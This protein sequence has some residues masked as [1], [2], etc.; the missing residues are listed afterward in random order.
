MSKG[1]GFWKKL[2]AVLA[3]LS[4]VTFIFK[5]KLIK[6]LPDMSNGIEGVGDSIYTFLRNTITG[7]VLYSQKLIGGTMSS[8]I[9]YICKEILP[10]TIGTFFND[11]L[12]TALVVA[13]LSVMSMLSDSAGKQLEDYLGTQSDARG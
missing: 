13:T 4:M 8:V 2:L 9:N 12:P 5:D 10:G 6:M 3:I 7:M 11:T 1:N